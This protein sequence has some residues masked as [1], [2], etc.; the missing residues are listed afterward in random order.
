MRAALLNPCSTF[1]QTNIPNIQTHHVPG[2]LL[3]GLLD[4]VCD[5]YLCKEIPKDAQGGNDFQK[6]PGSWVLSGLC[7]W[8]SHHRRT[9]YTFNR[10][11]HWLS[12]VLIKNFKFQLKKRKNALTMP[13][14]QRKSIGSMRSIKK[15]VTGPN[16]CS[17]EGWTLAGLKQTAW[18]NG[19]YMIIE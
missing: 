2:T 4:L 12:C 8:D 1:T 18:Y 19:R 6:P 5:L 14:N 17:A 13:V 9:P 3:T 7:R 15:P 11:Q 10:H 16:C